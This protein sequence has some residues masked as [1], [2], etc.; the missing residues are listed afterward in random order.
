MPDARATVVAGGVPLAGV[1]VEFRIGTKVVC[2]APTN[3]SGVATCNAASQLVALVLNAG[4]TA[5]FL[6]DANHLSSTARG[7]ILK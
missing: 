7:A 4:Y 3:A 1:P 5:S 6:G 2:V